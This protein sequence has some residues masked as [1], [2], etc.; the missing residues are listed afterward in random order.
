[1]LGLALSATSP[2]DRV[3]VRTAADGA[4]ATI[5]LPLC[6]DGGDRLFTSVAEPGQ[7]RRRDS[8]TLM[9]C[10]AIAG[11]H[12]GRLTTQEQD[13]RTVLVVWLPE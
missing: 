4:G 6:G 2:G 3:D 7:A 1:M 13:G 12:R 11:R 5:Q 8:M 10:R 9:L